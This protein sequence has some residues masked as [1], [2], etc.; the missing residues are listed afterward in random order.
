MKSEIKN[1]R[2]KIYKTL[3]SKAQALE[4][5]KSREM[6][7]YEKDQIKFS[8]REFTSSSI[9]ELVT[10]VIDSNVIYLGDFHTFD[11]NIR[12]V[13]RVLKV[14]Q[15]SQSQCIIA[16]EMVDAKY[17]F[18]ID[19]FLE[20][21][22]TELEFLESIHYHDSWRFPWTHYNLIFELAKKENFKVLALN[23]SGS[24]EER[25]DFAADI[26]STVLARNL[27]TQILVVYGELHISPDK[28][29]N[30]V[31]SL[32]DGISQTIIHQNLDEVYWK[33]LD[34]DQNDKIIQFNE[35]EFCIN[36]A[37]PWI[38]YESMLYWYE[39]L[40]DDPEFDI[41][42]YIIENGKKI[43]G[44]DA[45]DNF[46]LLSEEMILAMKLKITRDEVEDFNLLDHTRLERIEESVSQLPNRKVR[47]FYTQLITLGYSFNLPGE[48]KLYCSSYSMNR[49]AYLAGVHIYHVYLDKFK[50]ETA[51]IIYGQDKAKCFTLFTFEAMYAY[52]FSK[53][54][55]PHRKCN[56][57]LD[58]KDQL[59]KDKAVHEVIS[60][61]LN[62]LDDKDISEVFNESE[63]ISLFETALNIGHIFGEYLYMSIFELTLKES[64][65]TTFMKKSIDKKSFNDVKELLF[66]NR[67]IKKDRKRYF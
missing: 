35:N 6:I 12:N 47:T 52:F 33:L 65:E 16:L 50:V 63:M 29:P 8:K 11:Q 27:E 40:T 37:P 57:Y 3:K 60:Q 36:S 67:E 62:V 43:F 19:S 46:L 49:L 17:Q 26:I 10:R 18:Y 14:L 21:H 20:G 61:T 55:N 9:E 5:S 38:K 23:T 45:N 30:R 54:I 2:K 41:H 13:L 42:E 64:I 24:L 34:L 28:I 44:D 25:D 56:M 48:S 59:K 22:I 39:N 51:P 66:F 15:Q 1:L 4:G 58:Y 7:K 32:S 31:K 53:V